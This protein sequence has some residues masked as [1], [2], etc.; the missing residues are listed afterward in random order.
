MVGPFWTVLETRVRNR[1]PFP[2]FLKQL[3]D[4]HQVE[5]CNIP[6]ET[7]QHLNEYIP[8]TPAAVL[9]AEVGPTPY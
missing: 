7:V 6:L 1:F 8:R 3:E 4:V 2:T 9:K 5:W